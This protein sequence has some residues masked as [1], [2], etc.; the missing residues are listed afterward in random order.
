MKRLIEIDLSLAVLVAWVLFVAVV[1]IRAALSEPKPSPP[2][3]MGDLLPVLVII[4][5]PPCL[6]WFLKRDDA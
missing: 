6:A 1:V 5:G 3:V 4:C 2:L